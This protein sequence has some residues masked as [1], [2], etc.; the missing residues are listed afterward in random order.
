MP[1]QDPAHLRALAVTTLV[2]LGGAALSVLLTL[3]FPG[4]GAPNPCHCFLYVPPQAWLVVLLAPTALALAFATCISGFRQSRSA[5][6]RGWMGAFSVLLLLLVLVPTYF[7]CS[8][9]ATLAGPPSLFPL[10]Q[11]PGTQAN[12]W[13]Q[14]AGGSVA[15][16][17]VTA[18]CALAYASRGSSPDRWLNHSA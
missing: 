3:A 11:G 12:T 4:F 7:I 6:Q 5:G 13:W 18:I 17:L 10:L 14:L 15:V 2:T 1:D 9:G 16:M 8:F